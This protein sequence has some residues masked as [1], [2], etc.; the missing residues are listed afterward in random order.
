M[1]F[2]AI[3]VSSRGCLVQ[4]EFLQSRRV[5]FSNFRF[6]SRQKTYELVVR[7]G[8]DDR[9]SVAVV[10]EDKD[11]VCAL[12]RRKAVGDD[13]GGPLCVLVAHELVEACLHDLLAL[14]VECAAG[15][16]A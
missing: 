4:G 3:C 9:R 13:D 14:V 16:D 6:A 2:L 8:L 11:A 1:P 12:D 15:R 10:V 5:A 7:A